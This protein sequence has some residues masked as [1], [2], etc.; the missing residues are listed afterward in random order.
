MWGVTQ[1]QVKQEEVGFECQNFIDFSSLPPFLFEVGLSSCQVASNLW[2][3][4]SSQSSLEMPSQALPY[5]CL[6]GNS[7]SSQ[8]NNKDCLHIKLCQLIQTQVECF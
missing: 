6:L 3:V 5:V 7:N 1:V 2:Q 4:L 8:G